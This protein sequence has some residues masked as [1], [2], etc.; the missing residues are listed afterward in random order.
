MFQIVA[1]SDLA[2]QFAGFLVA[3]RKGKLRDVKNGQRKNLSTRVRWSKYS[4]LQLLN[5]YC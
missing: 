4:I 3:L 5:E 2:L 1:T